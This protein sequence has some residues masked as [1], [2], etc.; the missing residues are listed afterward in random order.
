MS[1]E[2]LVGSPSG[3]CL[4]SCNIDVPAPA[5]TLIT[6]NSR[7][8]MAGG[9][10][11]ML[12]GGGGDVAREGGG[13]AFRGWADREWDPEDGLVDCVNAR[14]GQCAND[15]AYCAGAARLEGAARL[16]FPSIGCSCTILD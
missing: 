3:C 1:D 4:P 8:Y 15:A 10:E 9:L 6:H 5:L 16:T 14:L 12:R 13:V 2:P 7:G 11:E